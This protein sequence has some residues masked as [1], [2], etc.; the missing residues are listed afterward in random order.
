MEKEAKI[1][2][3]LGN[4]FHLSV[5][6][7][8]DKLEIKKWKLFRKYENGDPIYYSKDNQAIM[9]SETHTEEDLYKFSKLHQKYDL[10]KVNRK[11]R[12]IIL[13]IMVVL[14]IINMFINSNVISTIVLTS[15]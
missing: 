4:R 6:C 13:F 1:R 5:S 11:V 15:N 14:A 2:K 12:T 9:T 7:E 10:Y 3:M 8:G